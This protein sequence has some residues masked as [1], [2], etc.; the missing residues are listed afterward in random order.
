MTLEQEIE[1]LKRLS[2]LSLWHREE[3]ERLESK[4]KTL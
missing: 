2:W 1:L 3:L 4:A